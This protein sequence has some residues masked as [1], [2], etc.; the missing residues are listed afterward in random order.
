MLLREIFDLVYLTCT[1]PSVD[2]GLILF[3]DFLQS[4][5]TSL[6]PGKRR[7]L[8][9]RFCRDLL[10]FGKTLTRQACDSS[11]SAPNIGQMSSP[12]LPIRAK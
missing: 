7:Y 9:G 12:I 8:R 4:P 11:N 5:G 10:G 3:E 6:G 2:L 1:D